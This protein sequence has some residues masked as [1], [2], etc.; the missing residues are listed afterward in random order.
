MSGDLL[1]S[2]L[3][4]ALKCAYP[5]PVELVGVGGEGLQAG[6]VLDPKA[7]RRKVVGVDIDYE[8]VGEKGAMLMVSISGT[9]VR[10]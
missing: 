9:A 5:G 1:G 8:V 4:A 6:T 2:D 7:S 10:F 3:I